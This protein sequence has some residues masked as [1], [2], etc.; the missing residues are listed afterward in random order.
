MCNESPDYLEFPPE[1]GLQEAPAI[2]GQ[3]HE[4][5]RKVDAATEG[6]CPAA[7]EPRDGDGDYIGLT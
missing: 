1:Q 5:H 2:E 4:I 7:V 3:R 6:R